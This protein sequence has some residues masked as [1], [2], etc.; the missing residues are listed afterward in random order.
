MFINSLAINDLEDT[1]M[2]NRAIDEWFAALKPKYD[3]YQ[4]IPVQVS[5]YFKY[6]MDDDIDFRMKTSSERKKYYIEYLKNN[7]GLHFLASGTN[8]MCFTSEI[9]PNVIVKLAYNSGRMN[10][11]NEMY[12]QDKLKPHVTKTF[13]STPDGIFSLHERVTE[14]GSKEDLLPF[15]D[16]HFFLMMDFYERG[17][18][19]ED[20]GT[21]T[22]RNLGV[23]PNYGLVLLDYP[24]VFRARPG[25]LKCHCGGRIFYDAGFNRIQCHTCGHSYT[26]SSVAT[27]VSKN[28]LENKI[29]KPMNEYNGGV[30]MKFSVKFT[31]ANGDVEVKEY[32]TRTF[33]SKPM[34]KPQPKKPEPLKPVSMFG[35]A[36]LGHVKARLVYSDGTPYTGEESK[37]KGSKFKDEARLKK[38]NRNNRKVDEAVSEVKEIIAPENFSETMPRIIEFEDDIELVTPQT[39][40]KAEEPE[41]VIPEVIV[42][43]IE[44]VEEAPSAIVGDVIDIEE[45]TPVTDEEFDSINHDTSIFDSINETLSYLFTDDLR[46]DIMN[47]LSDE[48]SNDMEVKND[49][50]QLGHQ[51]PV[52]TE[53]QES[54]GEKKCSKKSSRQSARS[55]GVRSAKKNTERKVKEDITL[56]DGVEES[57]KYPKKSKS[58]KSSK[59]NK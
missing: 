45:T 51:Q 44:E 28:E 48:V 47:A 19:L 41:V 10:A 13:G 27:K 5:S 32:D 55:G 58:G 30:K 15:A 38:D 29:I 31:S 35:G 16:Q 37:K 21:K 25:D 33:Q 42:P 46:N 23:R 12:I 14:I 7:A 22:F 36:E 53:S 57:S 3:F 34:P 6:L 9:D 56:D 49:D 2:S 52:E 18:I 11:E 8:R 26:A 1:S 24:T 4:Y 39:R 17:F 50:E 20:V 59:K 54:D 43:V 40:V